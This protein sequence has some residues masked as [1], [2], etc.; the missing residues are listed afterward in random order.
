L[1]LTGDDL[2]SDYGVEFDKERANDFYGYCFQGANK[3]SGSDSNVPSQFITLPTTADYFQ[4]HKDLQEKN[5][6][7]QSERILVV[8]EDDLVYDYQVNRENFKCIR[9]HQYYKI[10]AFRSQSLSPKPQLRS[11]QLHSVNPFAK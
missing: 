6:Y 5:Q 4:K 10:A 9:H 3:Y 8:S 7:Q 11:Y 1:A 2:D